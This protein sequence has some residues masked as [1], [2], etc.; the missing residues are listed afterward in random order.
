MLG[1]M[2]LQI[3]FQRAQGQMYIKVTLHISPSRRGK[4]TIT[5]NTK[6][7]GHKIYIFFREGHKI[8]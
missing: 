1:G 5:T 3:V 6:I 4:Y 8:Y 2:N 7:L